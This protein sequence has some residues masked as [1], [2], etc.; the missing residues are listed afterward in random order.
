MLL[1]RCVVDR[2]LTCSYEQRLL[3]NSCWVL[4]TKVSCV[5][6]ANLFVLSV[7]LLFLLLVLRYSNAKV[8]EP[9]PG[10]SALVSLKTLK[11]AGLGWE[12]LF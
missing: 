9:G 6:G 11:Y 8:P 12:T 3:S 7:F 2:M 1:V 10:V 4:P 5:S